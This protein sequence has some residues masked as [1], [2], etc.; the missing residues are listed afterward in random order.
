M[1]GLRGGAGIRLPQ[2]RLSDERRPALPDRRTSPRLHLGEIAGISTPR[3]LLV[4]RRRADGRR[5]DAACLPPVA[6]APFVPVRAAARIPAV[7]LALACVAAGGRARRGFTRAGTGGRSSRGSIGLAPAASRPKLR[8]MAD[9]AIL[10]LWRDRRSAPQCQRWPRSLPS[11]RCP[12][13]FVYYL[14][15]QAFHIQPRLRRRPPSAPSRPPSVSSFRP[16]P[17][18]SAS[19]ARSPIGTL[20]KVF[21]IDYEPRGEH[22]PRHPPG[23]LRAADLRRR[24]LHVARAQ[25]L[26]ARDASSAGSPTARRPLREPPATDALRESPPWRYSCVAMSCPPGPRPSFLNRARAA[27]HASGAA[28]PHCHNS[29]CNR[30]SAR[31]LRLEPSGQARPC[32]SKCRQRLVRLPRSTAAPAGRPRRPPSSGIIL[33]VGSPTPYPACPGLADQ[34]VR[35]TDASTAPSSS[36]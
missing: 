5:V 6:S 23:L 13:G 29:G 12:I 20:T 3:S 14:G 11:P 21:G 34:S 4:S 16:P 8:Q 36:G 15:F 24:S 18:A 19:I 30:C 22:R 33:S 2:R 9:N 31:A 1:P 17:G 10:R 28:R 32:A 26:A 25:G 27:C 7:A 35:G